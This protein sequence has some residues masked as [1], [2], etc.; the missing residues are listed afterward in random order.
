MLFTG[1]S[2]ILFRP[3]K[4]FLGVFV[5]FLRVPFDALEPPVVAH[6]AL[7]LLVDGH[8]F[9]SVVRMERRVLS[10]QV[11]LLRFWVKVEN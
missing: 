3:G 4:V 6:G 11:R 7:V 10:F 8:E 9:A 5:Y 1:I 2:F